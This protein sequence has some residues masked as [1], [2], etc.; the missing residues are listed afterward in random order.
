MHELEHFNLNMDKE[1]GVQDSDIGI[2][3]GGGY[4][5]EF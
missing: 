3:T 2:E 1:P 4:G 5:T